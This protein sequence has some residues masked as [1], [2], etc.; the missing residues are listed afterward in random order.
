MKKKAIIKTSENNL[1]KNPAY[2]TKR[3]KRKIRGKRN[4][5]RFISEEKIPSKT[6]ERRSRKQ[7]DRSVRDSRLPWWL[8]WERTHLPAQEMQV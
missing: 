7:L 2:Q 3:K 8:S 1:I 4:I 6:G 5:T